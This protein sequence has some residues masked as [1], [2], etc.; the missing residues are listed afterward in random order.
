MHPRCAT[1]TGV[2]SPDV[3]VHESLSDPFRAY[4]MLHDH[5]EQNAGLQTRSTFRL[6][7]GAALHM[8]ANL[9]A[10]TAL[11]WHYSLHALFFFR[12]CCDLTTAFDSPPPRA[13]L[14]GLEEGVASRVCRARSSDQ[15]IADVM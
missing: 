13:M 6:L 12:C 10:G 8:P 7:G 3:M 15:P 5:L 4:L 1:L 9:N 11:C 14:V 2:M